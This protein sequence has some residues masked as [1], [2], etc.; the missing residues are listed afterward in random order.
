MSAAVSAE[1]L[2]ELKEKRGFIKIKRKYY[3]KA[4][5]N[6]I[7]VKA[8]ADVTSKCAKV[9]KQT[10]SGINNKLIE[11]SEESVGTDTSSARGKSF[12]FDK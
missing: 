3:G 2:T 11:Q 9:S 10:R 5:G 12:A 4:K 6:I 8:T 7:E 1:A